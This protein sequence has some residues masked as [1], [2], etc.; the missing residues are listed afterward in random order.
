MAES[1]EPDGLKEGA[2]LLRQVLK[3]I[4]PELDDREDAVLRKVVEGYAAQPTWRRKSPPR[5]SQQPNRTAMSRRPPRAGPRCPSPAHMGQPKYPNLKG[6]R[7]FAGATESGVGPRRRPMR[8]D[9]CGIS[10]PN[11]SL[12]DPSPDRHSSGATSGIRS[13]QWMLGRMSSSLRS[14][15]F[16]QRLYT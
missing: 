15:E 4:P 8:A 7:P 10:A 16:S 11:D 5:G 13:C 2:R 9:R 3:A 6:L 12:R 1:I 14:N